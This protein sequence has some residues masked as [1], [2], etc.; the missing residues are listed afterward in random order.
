MKNISIFILAIIFI[1][2]ISCKKDENIE[3]VKM[4]VNHYQ[5]PLNN[6]EYFYGL[7]FIVQEGDEIGSDKWYGFSNIISGFDYELG[8]VYDI[9]IQ[10]KHI[11][12]TMIDKAN[13]EYS[14]IRILSKTKVPQGTTF[15]ITLT[16]NYSNGFESLVT[17]NE[18]SIFTLLGETEIDCGNLCGS[19][20]EKI[21]NQKGL[22]G[23]FAHID[24]KTIQLL[25]LKTQEK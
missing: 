23:T 14:L 25:N 4:R 16:I 9:E 18:V 22:I 17:K 24:D 20:E 3:I 13:V 6:Q 1:C 19:L 10:K 7:S 21:K 15:D 11:K 12:D 2:I 5:Q 8:Y